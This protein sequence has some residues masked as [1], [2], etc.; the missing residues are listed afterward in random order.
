LTAQ[1]VELCSRS[2]INT[3]L[4]INCFTVFLSLIFHPHWLNACVCQFYLLNAA[5]AVELQFIDAHLI[6]KGC[7]AFEKQL[8]FM[9]TLFRPVT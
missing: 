8:S 6:T 5:V 2:T 9:Q 4:T 1:V 3:S 7:L